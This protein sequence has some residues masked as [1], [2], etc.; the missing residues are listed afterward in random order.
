MTVV[1]RGLFQWDFG[2]VF[3]EKVVSTDLKEEK[4]RT[5]CFPGREQKWKYIHSKVKRLVCW[6]E[7][8]KGVSSGS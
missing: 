7:M 5:K 3:S 6:R 8:N 1:D 2:K 4:K